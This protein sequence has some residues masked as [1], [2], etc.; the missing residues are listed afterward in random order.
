MDKLVERTSYIWNGFLRVLCWINRD[1]GW[2]VWDNRS[3]MLGDDLISGI[4]STFSLSSD[5]VSYLNDYVLITFNHA[6][7][8]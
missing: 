7:T 3:I 6:H 4:N 2:K 1:M 8:L 5:M